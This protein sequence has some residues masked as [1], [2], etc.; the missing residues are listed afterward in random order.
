MRPKLRPVHIQPVIH[1][2]EPAVILQDPLQLSGRAVIIP[3]RLTPLLPLCDGTRDVNMLCI[4]LALRNNVHLSIHEMT[5]IV[6]RLDEAFLLDNERSAQAREMALAEYRA[7]PYRRPALAGLSYPADKDALR[8]YFDQLVAHVTCDGPASPD[9]R[10]VISPHIDYQRGGPVYARTWIQAAAA[11]AKADLAV[12]FGTD[13]NGS[14]GQITL[15]RQPYASLF[16]VS[17]IDSQVVDALVTAIGPEAAFAEELHH[18]HEHSIELVVTWLHYFLGDRCLPIVPILCGSLD[19]HIQNGS[20]PM[21]NPVIAAVVQALRTAT[22]GRRVLWIAAADLAHVGPAFGDPAPLDLWTRVR[23]RAADERLLRTI[24]AGDPTAFF[25]SVQGERDR[26]R[27]C[28][29]A[30]IYLTLQ[31][32]APATGQIIAY[33]HCPADTKNGSMVTI[34]GVLLC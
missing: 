29:T 15:T 11:V 9:V 33:E 27:V 26:W 31:M 6:Q 24:E 4:S 3:Y 2:G 23:L 30:P 10:A 19:H 25:W 28:G 22:A 32:V 1:A 21:T 18:R 17:P 14:S 34:A 7:A 12:V 16:G 20:D 13:H 5:Q 8:Q